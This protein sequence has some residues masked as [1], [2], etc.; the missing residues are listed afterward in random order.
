MIH[1]SKILSKASALTLVMV[2]S[3]IMLSAQTVL[4]GKIT[5]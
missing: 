5:D 4:R 1:M 3:G 2:F